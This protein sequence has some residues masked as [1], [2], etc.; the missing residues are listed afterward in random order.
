MPLFSIFRRWRGFTLVELLW[1]Q[2][3]TQAEAAAVLQ[4]AK[5]TVRR[6]WLAARRRLGAFLRGAQVG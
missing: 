3:M 1:Y 4:V 6:H 5:S 2:E